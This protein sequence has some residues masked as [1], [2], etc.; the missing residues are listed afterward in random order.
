MTARIIAIAIAIFALGALTGITAADA[1]G[2]EPAPTTPQRC[3]IVYING[4]T[5]IS[6]PT[7]VVRG[8]K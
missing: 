2:A 6:C 4:D 1:Y 7:L 8:G 3:R 5:V